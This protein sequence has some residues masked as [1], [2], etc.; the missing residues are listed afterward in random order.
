MAYILTITAATHPQ[1]V[2]DLIYM[3]NIEK[4]AGYL[5]DYLKPNNFRPHCMSVSPVYENAKFIIS[6]KYEN[7]KSTLK[8]V[9]PPTYLME[10]PEVLDRL[11]KA[12]F[13]TL[14]H[15]SA[16]H[17]KQ[18][19]EFN[20][21]SSP[22]GCTAQIDP[23]PGRSTDISPR[24]GPGVTT[25]ST[26]R[27]HV[28]ISE[29]EDEDVPSQVSRDEYESDDQCMLELT[30]MSVENIANQADLYKTVQAQSSLILAQNRAIK[31]LTS[32]VNEM[33]TLLRS[34]DAV[35]RETAAMIRKVK[36]D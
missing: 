9:L 21:N 32:K 31:Q 35:A 10:M 18:L 16:E 2:K 26:K 20:K 3:R 33:Y 25:R 15:L 19:R 1:D 14:H 11:V 13:I 29:D 24:S 7:S 4:T 36:I 28:V 6:K 23:L 22:T 34:M 8:S 30:R 12:D 17:K 5:K 27:A